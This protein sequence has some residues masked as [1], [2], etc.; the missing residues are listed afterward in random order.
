MYGDPLLDQQV[1]R[2]EIDPDFAEKIRLKTAGPKELTEDVPPSI[3]RF[4][5]CLRVLMTR[6]RRWRRCLELMKILI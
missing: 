5:C 6:S 1:H 3:V 4:Y 2:L